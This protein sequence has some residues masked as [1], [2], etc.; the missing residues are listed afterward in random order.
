VSIILRALLVQLPH[1]ERSPSVF[2]IGIANIATALSE[3]G[4]E[5]EILDIFALGYSREDVV[6]YLNKSHWDLIGISA[7]STQY[8]WAKWMADE[9]KRLHPQS[10]IIM[11]GPLATFNS[12]LILEKTNTDICVISEGE[13]TIKDIVRN[14]GDLSNVAG[15]CFKSANG[16]IIETS[17]RQYIQNLDNLPFTNYEVFPM[18][19]YFRNMG[20]DGVPGVKTINMLTS[21]GCPYKCNFCSRTFKGSRLRSIENVIEEIG[22]LRDKYGISGIAFADELVLVNKK[23]AYELCEKIKPLKIYWNCQGR[24]NIVDLQLL[25][26]MKAA[27]C[28][29]VG[30]GVESGSQNILDNMN[31]RVTV[32]QNELAIT[33]TLKAG[34]TPI[35]QMIYGYPGEDPVTIRETVEFFDRVHFYPPVGY[36]DAHVSLLTP[37]PGSP[38]YD[39]LLNDGRIKKEE[40]YLLG[41]EQGYFPG[42]PLLANLTQFTDEE[43]MSRRIKL[44]NELRA[45]YRKYVHKHPTLLI[46][47]YTDAISTIRAVEGISGLIRRYAW[48]IRRRLLKGLSVLEGK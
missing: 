6:E 7:Y 44:I 46:R 35:V 38:L 43:L 18:D 16:E 26:A 45:N 2:P 27:G 30:Y 15:I 39:D 34:M 4:V 31:K 21:R 19:V 11:G 20:M 14:L 25:K 42:C 33:N 28:T 8:P 5:S 3:V 1:K 9:A 13:E 48:F 32:K 47:R 41:L 12:I 23:R 40:E 29:S 22:L 17:Q 10:L 36:G 24:A 37:L